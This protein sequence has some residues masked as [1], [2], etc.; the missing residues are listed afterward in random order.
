MA[1]GHKKKGGGFPAII[2]RKDVQNAI[3]TQPYISGKE[4]LID[5]QTYK[6]QINPQFIY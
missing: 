5:L 4:L 6:T 3:N 1:K 2:T